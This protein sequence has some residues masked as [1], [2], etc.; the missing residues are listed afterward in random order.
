MKMSLTNKTAVVTGASSGLGKAVAELLA[1]EGVR[2][3]AMARNINQTKLPSEVI[4]IQCNIRDLHSIDEA[5]TKIDTISESIDYLINCAGRG[6]V[7]TFEETTREEIM[8]IFGVN[9]KGNIYIAQ[10]VYKRMIPN[11]SGHIVNVGSTSSIKAREMEVLYCASKWGLRGFTESLRLE[12]RKHG[13]KVTGVYP[14]GMKSENFWRI[15]PGK[16]IS[17]YM[18]PKDVAERI[19]SVITAD[20][21]IATTEV[22]IE[23]P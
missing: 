6:L 23:R 9:L 21:H 2:V 13:V 5:F 11:R 18:D 20:P 17:G 16:D 12:A 1:R 14:G 15:T 10:E 4:K 22:I 7:K 3:F 8:D 19:L